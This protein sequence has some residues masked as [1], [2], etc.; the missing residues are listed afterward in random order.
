MKTK[1]ASA[2]TVLPPSEAQGS[3]PSS[4]YTGPPNS[5]PLGNGGFWTKKAPVCK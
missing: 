1:R 5:V 4:G 3:R 2:V